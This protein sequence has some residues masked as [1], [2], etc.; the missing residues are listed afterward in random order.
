MF[1]NFYNLFKVSFILLLSNITI[2]NINKAHNLILFLLLIKF[3]LCFAVLH[4]YINNIII[5]III[6]THGHTQN[7]NKQ[8][9]VISLIYHINIVYNKINYTLL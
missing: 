7:Y 3:W 1:E 6:N 9:S 8:I 4:N 5:F 2:Y